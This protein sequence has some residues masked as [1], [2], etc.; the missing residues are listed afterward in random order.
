MQKEKFVANILI[1]SAGRRVSLVKYFQE[2]LRKVRPN[3]KVLT[4]DLKPELSSACTISDG[5]FATGRFSDANYMDELKRSCIERDVKLVIP[6]IDTE[7][8][9]LADHRDEFQESGI[10]LVVSDSAVVTKCNDKRLSNEFLC[11]M[12]FRIPKQQDVDDL[13]FPV[14]VK[15]ISGSSSQDLH[16][17]RDE[18]MVSDYL[19]QTSK[20]MHMEY[21]SPD[22]FDE[23]T[24]D[25]YYDRNGILKCVVPR[26]RI[27][28]R[29]GEINKGITC[30][31]IL[32]PFVEERLSTWEGA[33]GCFTLQVFLEKS[34]GEVFG[35]EVNPRFGGGYPL[36]HLAGAN[37]PGW[38][39][40]EYL[41]DEPVDPFDEWE[42]N[43]LLL[44]H[45]AE[46]VI[47]D[48]QY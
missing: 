22:E 37:Y 28:V 27:V 31:N 30:K 17:L 5:S 24:L 47:H 43:L 34:D 7:L 25:L 3:S 40:K 20:F 26:L 12:G 2:E 41:L 6:T 39:I 46:L 19:L 18:T 8:Q 42:E 11:S 45:D 1:S 4:T 21:L 16:L 33:R 29:G 44:R 23:Y 38:I 32:V 13:D 9:L 15:P 35:I 14:F 36:S 10:E 48:F